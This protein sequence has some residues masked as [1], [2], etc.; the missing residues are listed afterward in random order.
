MV[1][2][3][4]PEGGKDSCSGDS[5]G[6]LVIKKSGKQ[7]GIVSW[8]IGCAEKDHPGVYTNVADK[9][10]NDFIESELKQDATVSS[11]DVSKV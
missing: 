6:A 10:I 2:A 3:G 5:G 8:G 1:C 9:E 7:V 4:M 11:A